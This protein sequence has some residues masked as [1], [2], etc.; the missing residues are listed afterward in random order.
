MVE[1]A[2]RDARLLGD[3]AD[4]GRVEAL[5]REHAHGGVEDQAPFLLRSRR[6]L[7]QGRR[8]VVL[9]SRGCNALGGMLVIDLTRYLPGAFASSELLRLGARVVRVEQPGGEPMRETAPGW[10]DV[11]NAG[12]ES[13]VCDLPADAAGARAA[14]PGG[15]RARVVQARRRRAARRRARRDA[16]E[17]RLLLDHRLR[18]R[19]AATS[20]GRDMT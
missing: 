15:R 12:K 6:A 5:A 2:V 1:Q 20:S 3:V 18:A 9:G 11:L 10:H 17:R 4:T 19:R 16:G 14:R 13:V 7:G 8:R